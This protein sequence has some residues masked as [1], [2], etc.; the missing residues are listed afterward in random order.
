M[1][2]L[3]DILLTYGLHSTL[4][5][6]AAWL[7]SFAF[8]APP[9]RDTLWKAALVGALL[10]SGFQLA[11][12]WGVS[13]QPRMAPQLE[14][15][16]PQPEAT[17][18]APPP[19]ETQATSTV[20][21]VP[22]PSPAQHSTSTQHSPLPPKPNLP[23]WLS[24]Q[25][26]LLG[27]W[28]LGLLLCGLRLITAGR[29]LRHRLA[30]R[31][32]LRE[33]RLPALLA[34]LCHK[35]GV[36]RRVRLTVSP[37][38]ASPVAL[39]YREICLPERARSLNPV[40]QQVMLAHELAHLR[41]Y[42]PWW[43]LL[44]SGLE[45]LFWFQPLTR[46][47]KHHLKTTAEYL[48]DAWVV[49][50]A[51]HRLE[52]ARCLAEVAGWLQEKRALPLT[53]GMAGHSPLVGRVKRLLEG[54]QEMFTSQY[55]VQRLLLTLG[56]LALVSLGAPNVL[57]GQRGNAA[58]AQSAQTSNYS[59]LNLNFDVKSPQHNLPQGWVILGD[60]S[61]VG[62]DATNVYN[63][64]YS[65]RIHSKST[66]PQEFHFGGIMRTFPVSDVAKGK[67]IR[68][69]GYIKTQDVQGGFAA[70]WV[71][72]EGS[73]KYN[74][75]AFGNMWNQDVHGTTGWTRYQITLPVYDSVNAKNMSAEDI[76]FG[77]FSTGTGTAWFDDLSIQ[78]LNEPAA[79]Y[80]AFPPLK[81]STVAPSHFWADFAQRISSAANIS[82][83]VLQQRTDL[84][85][86]TAQTIQ[87][88]QQT[89]QQQIDALKRQLINLKQQEQGTQHPNSDLEKQVAVLEGEFAFLNRSLQQQEVNLKRQLAELKQKM[90]DLKKQEAQQPSH[91]LE[92]SIAVYNAV[93]DAVE[94]LLNQA[95]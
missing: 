54:S 58:L 64:S 31:R 35:T 34:D 46:L 49:R 87:T 1:R 11:T 69:T 47:G 65:L 29:D 25:T 52:L 44:A 42:D 19:V 75:L 90:T 48:C 94:N 10:S 30:S 70:L 88:T 22:Q 67:V 93:I 73:G 23:A 68:L 86:S 50:H 57:L 6:G 18:P 45:T 81:G 13:V 15:I 7:L 43:L 53:A 5:L 26:L 72:V 33:G 56:L 76:V 80:P 59:N 9:V 14:Q 12:G 2:I 83:Q 21:P 92:Q 61:E 63:G 84:L 8:K 37:E 24:W 41:R 28:F 78:V 4:L 95:Q 27:L 89:L 71:R 74:V 20:Q 32:P 55:K 60:K 40:R 85:N 51:G 39:G 66:S 16:A 62:L 17:T 3:T 79:A 91:G 38:L 77:V 82:Q 36:K